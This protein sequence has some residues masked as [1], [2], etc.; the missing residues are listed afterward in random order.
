M[1][2]ALSLILAL[3]LCLSLCACVNEDKN[4]ETQNTTNQTTT[5]EDQD[6]NNAENTTTENETNQTELQHITVEIT[7]DN[8]NQYFEN[9]PYVKYRTN[10]FDEII[11]ATI[12]S[13]LKL[14][15]EYE[16]LEGSVSF[17]IELQWEKRECT[18]DFAKG[19]IEFGEV[20][21][22]EGSSTTTTSFT[23]IAFMRYGDYITTFGCMD[24]VTRDDADIKE[25]TVTTEVF[26]KMLR[27]EGTLILNSK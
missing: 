17:E 3:V 25:D 6:T 10:D 26:V 13:S 23:D 9:V 20:I 14:K 11:T 4:T 16:Y 18:V 8:W 24:E 1:K 15:E 27:A 5:E 22:T 7:I 21:K 2:K 19:S 12:G